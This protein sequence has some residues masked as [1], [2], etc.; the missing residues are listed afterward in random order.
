MSG[1]GIA[2]DALPLLAG[3]TTLGAVLLGLAAWLGRWRLWLA[4]YALIVLALATAFFF[5]DPPRPGERGPS[6][7]LSSADGRVVGVERLHDPRY[8]Q[9]SP[10]GGVVDRVEHSPGPF[11]PA[12]SGRAAIS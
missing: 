9:R 7:F 12:R 10:V 11:A 2:G 8:V 6:V 4:G 3:L 1:L 5:R